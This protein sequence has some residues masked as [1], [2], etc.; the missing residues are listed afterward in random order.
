M[1][2]LAHT[3][4]GAALAEAGLKRASRY[5]GAALV[6]GANLPDI[7][8]V[9]HLFG[10]DTALYARRGWSHGVLALAVLP[11]VLTAALLLWQRWFGGGRGGAPPVR[12][13]ALLAVACLGVWSHPLL[14]WMNTYG[15]RLLMP[16]DDRW[17]YGD[18]LFIV[19][20]WL[21]LLLAAGVV[22]AHSNGW[23]ARSSWLLLGAIASWLLL[24]R[25][26]PPGVVVAWSLGL[27]IIIALRWRL[28]VAQARLVAQ[29]GVAAALLYG[30]GLFGLAR[31]AE[32][33]AL[34]RFPDASVVQAS[35]I[36]GLP[37]RHR[38][39]LVHADRYRLIERDG[40]VLELAREPMDAT[41]QRAF[42]D[43][44]IRGFAGW[45]R[46]LW[47]QTEPVDG[48]LRV[49]FHD[50]R[51]ARPESRGGIGVAEVVVRRSVEEGSD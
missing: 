18:A 36:G 15:V 2:P 23:L 41:V 11:L 21:W 48:G 31:Q 40:S 43:P 28:P 51:Y 50:L 49:R 9:A 19:D 39:V 24:S 3:L 5:A 14:D 42:A 10:G 32:A 17:F 16:F 38:I 26:P 44:S 34:A 13:R 8:V 46:L 29:F 20:P 7:D 1:D 30:A 47:W 25:A 35:P 6:I 33:R 27:A 22:L 37:H 12:P 4:F 45:A